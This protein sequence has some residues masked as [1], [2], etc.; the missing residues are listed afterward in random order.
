MGRWWQTIRMGCKSLALHPLRSVLT[1]LG[2]FIGVASVIWLLAIGEGISREAQRQIEDLGADTIIVRSVK[3]PAEVIS[4]RRGPTP[5][6]LKRAEYEW[7]VE[8]VPTI[9]SALPIREI[10]RQFRYKDRLVDGRLVGCTPAYSDAN[11]LVVARGRFL[12]EA[13]VKRRLDVCVLAARVAE[14]LFPLE[15]PIGKRI[16]IA[17]HTD[18]YEVVGVLYHR[19]PSAAIGGSF[20]AQDYSNDVYIPI[21]TMRQRIGDI[22]VTRG[23]GTFEGEILEL[24]QIT[25][26]VRHIRDVVATAQLI[27]DML[28]PHHQMNDVAVVVPLELLEQARTMRL[29]FMVF[30][31]LI[32]AI[33]LVV[34]GI[35]I[36]NI[37]LATV[38]ER[39]REIGIRRALGARRVDIVRQFLVETVALSVVGGVCGIVA[40]YACPWA[41][42][43]LRDLLNT[44]APGTMQSLP[45]V[46]RNV[47][48]TVLPW[49]I[50]L[51]FGISVLIGVTFG[52]YPAVR[53]A[54][55]D[56][57]EALRRQ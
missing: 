32:A 53:A 44:H 26:R 57:I 46:V 39:T 13:D 4:D 16:Y 30:M 9:K 6:G 48:P 11:K 19:N 3:P 10:R 35:G 17:E 23:S 25:L 37:M 56:P 43:L 2:I 47:Q 14:R 34:G 20:S 55:M 22:V 27:E 18:F 15:D 31:G 49:S 41:V 7:I 38:T 8:T 42:S 36:M 45:A 29:M 51:A 54:H 24:N 52:L 33:S 28:R 12:E 1:I 5:Y 40:G 50:P 21:S